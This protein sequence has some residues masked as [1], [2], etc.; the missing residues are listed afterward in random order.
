MGVDEVPWRQGHKYPTL[1]NQIAAG[2]Q[3]LRWRGP[4]GTAKTLIR[5]FRF[6]SRDRS[7]KGQFVCRYRW[8][9]GLKVISKCIVQVGDLFGR[10]FFAP[11]RVS[12]RLCRVRSKEGVKLLTALSK[13]KSFPSRRWRPRIPCRHSIADRKWCDCDLSGTGTTDS[14]FNL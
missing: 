3:R 7:A 2:C 6:Q 12:T 9:D 4:G 14:D 8:Q 11:T 10:C 5:C 13:T 1:V